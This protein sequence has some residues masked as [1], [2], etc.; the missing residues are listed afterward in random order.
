MKR[1]VI[2]LTGGAKFIIHALTARIA[3]VRFKR[4]VRNG[5]VVWND[6]HP[7]PLSA[8]GEI[9]SVTPEP[10]IEHKPPEESWRK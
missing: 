3:R 10:P 6:A 4:A 9:A 7:K 8:L 1:Y 2:T 5:L